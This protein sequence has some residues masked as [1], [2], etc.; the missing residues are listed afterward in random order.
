MLDSG[1]RPAEQ[2]VRQARWQYDRITSD[3]FETALAELHEHAWDEAACEE[4][5]D[6]DKLAGD[7]EG[8]G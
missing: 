1:V 2:A 3:R 6:G 8:L 7:P 5:C 4:F